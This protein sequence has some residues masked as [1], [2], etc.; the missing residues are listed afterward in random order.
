VQNF[1]CKRQKNAAI[2]KIS[3]R[4]LL[5]II[6]TIFNIR[7]ISGLNCRLVH[8]CVHFKMWN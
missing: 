5:K 4:C 8:D 3:R 6:D 7:H 1:K 2:I